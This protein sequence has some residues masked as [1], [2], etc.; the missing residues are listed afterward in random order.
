MEHF[1]DVHF[2]VAKINGEEA[3]GTKATEQ[4]GTERLRP[5]G[6]LDSC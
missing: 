5:H 2:S 1:I 3:A 6:V 4:R